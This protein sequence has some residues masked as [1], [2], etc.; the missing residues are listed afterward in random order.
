[1]AQEE[2]FLVSS[3]GQNSR[4][5]L[6]KI[7]LAINLQFSDIYLINIVKCAS[8]NSKSSFVKDTE[9]ENYI[10]KKINSVQPNLVI[11]LGLVPIFTFNKVSSIDTLRDKI[12][13]YKNFDIVFTYHPQDLIRDESLKSNAWYDFKL[14]KHNYIN[15]Q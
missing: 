8:L 14:I 10:F 6:E 12:H 13:K 5:L 11:C 15:G 7:L 3:F 4:Q 2:D 1:M 9:C